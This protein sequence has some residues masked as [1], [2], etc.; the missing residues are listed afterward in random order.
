MTIGRLVK[1]AAS[2]IVPA[3]VVFDGRHVSKPTVALTFDDGPHTENTPRLLDILDRHD[4]R[5]TFFL[6]G[7]SAE[8]L[9]ELVLDIVRRGHQVGNHGYS[10]LSAR[11]AP[12][13]TYVADVNRC[14]QVLRSILG[15]GIGK[16][17]RPPY[18]HVSWRSARQL[19]SL[20]YR[21]VFW[22][23]DPHESEVNTAE[24]V[25]ANVESGS[26]ESGAITLF[27]DDYSHTL[28]AMPRILSYFRS[29][30]LKLVTVDRL[31]SPEN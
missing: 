28:D 12:C 6:Q 27:H 16:D 23:F 8:R 26:I 19:A 14:D 18:G 13:E 24:A 10:H 3:R 1:L 7:A 2:R 29:R 9:P 31:V 17:F 30:N 22:S 5:A 15:I 4:A 11:K 25:F 20:G 21:F